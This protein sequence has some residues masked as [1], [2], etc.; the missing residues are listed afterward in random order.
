[1]ELDDS[2]RDFQDEYTYMNEVTELEEK[3]NKQIDAMDA[4][5]AKMNEDI[6]II[7]E[8]LRAVGGRIRRALEA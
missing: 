2:P 1:M 7:E 8:D 5:L 6:R 3:C 4:R